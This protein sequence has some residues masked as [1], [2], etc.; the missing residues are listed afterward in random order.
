[1]AGFN[2]LGSLSYT[3]VDGS[4][5]PYAGA[6]LYV[7]R[8][9]TSTAV[10]SYTTSALSVANTDPV[11]ADGNG[12]FT[13]VW[14]DDSV[15]YDYRVRITT[16]TGTLLLD[17]DNIPRTGISAD[18][19]GR[20]L[21]P[22]STAEQS[23]GV[24]PSAYQYPPGD[25]RRYGALCDGSTNDT[26]AITTAISALPTY[27]G[28]L[29]IP[30]GVTR[31]QGVVFD[32]SDATIICLGWLKP[33]SNST[34][35]VWTFG[36]DSPATVC[37]RIRGN[38]NVGDP[39]GAMST[40]SSVPAIS[41]KGLVESNITLNGYA[42]NRGLL[43]NPAATAVAYNTFYLG[44]FFSCEQGVR[45]EPSSTGYCNENVFIG[46]RFS[47]GSGDAYNANVTGVYITTGANTVNGNKFIG[48]NFEGKGSCIY[49]DGNQN[50]F[51]D[52]RYETDS[53]GTASTDFADEFFRFGSNAY[54]NEL[55]I[56]YAPEFITSGWSKSHGAGTR[57]SDVSFTIAGDL[58]KWLFPGAPVELTVGGTT[59]RTF[60]YL[61]SYS[62]PD[63][64]VY[65]TDNIVT[66]SPTAVKTGRITQAVGGEQNRVFIF[67]NDALPDEDGQSWS[68]DRYRQVM[69]RSS[70][71]ISNVS[72]NFP[73]LTLAPAASGTERV[74]E[75][76][77]FTGV[78]AHV[79]ADGQATFAKA[80]VTTAA[81]TV[82]SGQVGLGSSVQTTVGSAGAASALPANPTGYLIINVAGTNRVVPYYAAS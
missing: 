7:Y 72:A 75:I 3:P 32:K 67:N 22:Q 11:V 81:P 24:T 27:G 33:V 16:S 44:T 14:V 59:Y 30:E 50:V 8:A 51:R 26:T 48:P 20:K 82:S 41:F 28:V 1:M 68:V 25:I 36:K 55:S 63:T 17:Q 23:A 43:F 12:R 4:G 35:A 53:T 62:A 45:M 57:T 56:Q 46:G 37:Y 60:V 78:N 58:R 40:W 52:V 54:G 49:C 70:L 71:F 9:G 38:L 66:G 10:T 65:V 42:T 61:S 2:L 29:T 76:A 34:T 15:S 21:Y 74:L 13:N 77:D 5:Q 79:R 47:V 6:L 64:T 69:T 31:A 73:A 19:V 80:V 39:A 18:T